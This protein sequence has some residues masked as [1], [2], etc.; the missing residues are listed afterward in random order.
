VAEFMVKTK[1]MRS[2]FGVIEYV[3]WETAF[4]G[5]TEAERAK[6]GV[7]SAAELER[8]FRRILEDPERFT[9]DEVSRQL[10]LIPPEKRPVVEKQ[11]EEA[12]V[13][14]RLKQDAMREFYRALTFEIGKAEVQGETATVPLTT[15]IHGKTTENIVT[16]IK[17]KGQWRLP[18]VEF[19]RPAAKS[20][21]PLPPPS[22]TI[23]PAGKPS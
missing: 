6:F 9:R 3:D 18:S 21:N 23:A 11:L 13:Q 7:K 1:T 8:Y 22:A 20:Q 14:V 2:P 15:T 10:L 4:A 17:K 5:T 19:A 16:L 12:L